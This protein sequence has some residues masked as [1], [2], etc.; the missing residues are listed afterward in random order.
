[1]TFTEFVKLK[2]PII[3]IAYAAATGALK[4]YFISQ[5]LCRLTEIGDWY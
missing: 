5:A 2:P 1:M 3:F 4:F